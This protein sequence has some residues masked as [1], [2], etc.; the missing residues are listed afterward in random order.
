MTNTEA[1]GVNIGELQW[2]LVATVVVFI[3]GGCGVSDLHYAASYLHCQLCHKVQ[4]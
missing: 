2:N 1:Q 4:S 3:S